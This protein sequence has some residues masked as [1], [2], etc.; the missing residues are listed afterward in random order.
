M[1]KIK[2]GFLFPLIALILLV[3]G[4]SIPVFNAP[5]LGMLLDPFIGVVQNDRD[6]QLTGISV[7]IRQT[8]LPHT[9]EVYF[10]ERKVPHIYADNT[11][12]L[13]FTQGYVTAA[14]RLW[15][16]DFAAYAAAGRLSEIF[17]GDRFLAY[18]RN[19]RRMGLLEAAR[20]SLQ[21]METDPETMAA[22]NAYTKGVNAYIQTLRYR[23]YPLEYKI[24]NYSPEPWS[25]LKSV[26]VMKQVGNNMTGYEEDMMMSKLMLVLGE[27]TFNKLYPDFGPH[28]TPVMDKPRQAA[29]PA[30]QQLKKPAYLDYAFLS[31]VSAITPSNY[32]PRLGSNSWAV[33][34]KKTKSGYPMLAN[35]PHLTLSL[36][37]VWLEMQLSA[38]GMNVYGVSIPGTPAVIIGFNDRVAWGIT[39]GADD[40]KDW[41]KLKIKADYS[42]YELDGKWIT[43]PYQVE[44]F[45]RRGGA[46]FYDTIY[47]TVHGPLVTT[48]SFPDKRP[49]LMNYALKWELLKASNEFSTFIKLARARNYEDFRGALKSYSCPVMNFTFAC[50]DN[51][52]A[53]HHQGS[54]RRKQAGEGRFVLDGSTGELNNSA[55]IPEDSLPRLVDPAVNYV[56]SANQHPTYADYRYYYNGYY[57]ETRAA[58][59][60]Q[61]LESS[62][63]FDIAGMERLQLDNTSVFA[64]EALPVLTGTLQRDKLNAGQQKMLNMLATW[65]G[66]Y[67]AG[68][69][70]ALLF[71]RWIKNIRNDTWDEWAAYSPALKAPPDFTLLSLI[72][73]EPSDRYFDKQGTSAKETAGDIVT[74]AFIKAAEEYVQ[75]SE[76]GSTAW[77]A[78]NKINVMHLIEIGAF[79]DTRIPVS[80]H[81]DAINAA[82]GSWG[83]S[84]RMIVELGKKPVAYGIYPGGQSGNAGSRYYDSGVKDWSAGKYYP[85]HFYQ[86]KAEAARQKGT[87]W[88][89]K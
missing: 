25:N 3:T 71:E 89:L 81:P 39:N 52:I 88:L 44:K 12:D 84:W 32:N 83:P 54:M 24:L 9:A 82:S 30:F 57:S 67:N 1:K 80:G 26:L 48:A 85:L 23:Q 59:I 87:V 5:P 50:N 28:V 49:E 69:T 2:A 40:I 37:N 65:K 29:S 43:L 56:L 70:A 17:R 68:D 76:K 66:T 41:Y 53:I 21:L 14:L 63:S 45:R 64:V 46:D 8:G 20:Q 22:L 72:S 73:N 42:Q 74:A 75:Q 79:S 13:F 7:T 61:L 16:M 19:Q 58:R 55:Y 10:D 4:L 77:A 60:R 86:S 51:T 36:P 47:H 34:G 38:P 35:D 78:S 62:D 33:S 31:S 27:D 15:Q 11:D 6:G 18:D